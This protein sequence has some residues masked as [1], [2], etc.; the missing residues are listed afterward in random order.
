MQMKP[1]LLVKLYIA[2]KNRT[3]FIYFVFIIHMI[4]STYNHWLVFWISSFLEFHEISL[5]L[6]ENIS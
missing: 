1:L 4:W 6:F 2:K 3:C 5:K